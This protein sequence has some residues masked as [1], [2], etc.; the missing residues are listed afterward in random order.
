MI[1]YEWDEEKRLHN[2][3]EHGL[4]F[5]RAK[6]VYENPNKITLRSTYPDEERLIDMAEVEERVLLLVYTIRNE[7]IRCISLRYAKRKTE[8][9]IYYEKQKNS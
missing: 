3:K 7:K 8:G 6:L 4:D 5:R 9:R 2:L 1:I